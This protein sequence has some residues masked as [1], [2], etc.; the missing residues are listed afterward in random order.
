MEIKQSLSRKKET[1]KYKNNTS[2]ENRRECYEASHYI[3]ENCCHKTRK[4]LKTCA[5]LSHYYMLIASRHCLLILPV[6]YQS[7]RS[8]ETSP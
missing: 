4:I 5:L 3:V 8:R 7:D 1:L 6:T 2:G